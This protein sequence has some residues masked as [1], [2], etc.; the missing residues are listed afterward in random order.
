MGIR[1]SEHTP[2]RIA[3]ASPGKTMTESDWLPCTAPTGMLRSLSDR[4]TSRKF[5]LFGCACCRRVWDFLG[6]E[7]WR[8]GGVAARSFVEGPGTEAD[9]AQRYPSA[10]P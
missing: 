8:A 9:F 6:D 7:R 2:A 4:L 5:R 1:P 3:T 10:R